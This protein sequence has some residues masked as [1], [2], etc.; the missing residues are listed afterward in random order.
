V[1]IHLYVYP[2]DVHKN[3]TYNRLMDLKRQSETLTMWV[4]LNPA[5]GPGKGVDANYTK[6]VDRLIGAGCV[7]LGLW[8]IFRLPAVFTRCAASFAGATR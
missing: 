2:R 7:V 3:S 1:P 5:S 6:A 4:I 8:R